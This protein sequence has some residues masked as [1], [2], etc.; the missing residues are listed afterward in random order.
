MRDSAEGGGLRGTPEVRRALEALAALEVGDDW[1]PRPP[2]VVEHMLADQ[3]AIRTFNPV[4]EEGFE[5]GRDYD[6]DRQRAERKKLRRQ[7]KKETRGAVRELRK[8][9]RYLA[10]VKER[11]RV[12]QKRRLQKAY[13]ETTADLLKAP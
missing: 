3:K 4:Y 12:A 6:V 1:G 8:D 5:R 11:E 7:L 9:N 2:L 13:A 10:E